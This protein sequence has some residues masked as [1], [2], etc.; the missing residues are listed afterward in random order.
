[1]VEPG[2]RGEGYNSAICEAVETE[3]RD[4]PPGALYLL[5]TTAAEFFR[6]RGYEEISRSDAPETIRQ[7]SEFDELCPATAT[8][9]TKSL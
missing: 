9:L 2:A 5:T 6:A 7:T 4:A 1:M 3:A 8:C